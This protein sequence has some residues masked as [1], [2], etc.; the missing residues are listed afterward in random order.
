[1]LKMGSGE[2]PLVV[3]MERPTMR[4]IRERLTEEGRVQMRLCKLELVIW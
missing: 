3:R 1:M 4:K 2:K